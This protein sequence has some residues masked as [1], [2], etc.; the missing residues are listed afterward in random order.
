MEEESEHLAPGTIVA[1]RYRVESLLGE[2]GMGVVY[3]AEHIHMR[4]RVALKVLLRAWCHTPEIIARFVREAIAAGSIDH[5]N[6][7]IAT[8]FGC[9]PNGLFFLVL[10]YVA[11][12]CLHEVLNEGPLEPDRAARIVRGIASAVGAA[13]ARGVIHRD[14]KPEN[15][16][17]VAREGEPDFVKVL[18][19]GIAKLDFG[20]AQGPGEALTRKGAV[21]GTP[22]YMAPEQAMGQPVDARAD[23]YAIGVLFYEMLSG[24]TPFRGGAMTVLRAHVMAPAPPIPPLVADKVD[25]RLQAIVMRLME[26]EPDAR[27]ASATELIAALDEVARGPARSV[28]PPSAPSAAKTV[29]PAKRSSPPAKPVASEGTTRETA[30]RGRVLI[31]AAVVVAMAV[32]LIASVA[33]SNGSADN[34]PDT[35]ENAVPLPPPTAPPADSTAPPTSSVPGAWTPPPSASGGAA[36]PQSAAAKQGAKR[37][38]GPGG[39]YIP[40]IKQWFK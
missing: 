24:K 28:R 15:I 27:Y 14:L 17:L 39:I 40:P 19:F 11:G 13:H 8:D 31:M 35:T 1:D 10:E 37:R 33:S 25:P 2:G 22:D 36:A 21:L 30:L 7:A 23:L 18:D 5:P 20:D 12:R 26:K 16:M 3:L 32:A 6:V 9:L 38:T 4:K 34:E 29:P